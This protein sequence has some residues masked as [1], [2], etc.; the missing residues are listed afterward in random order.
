[1]TSRVSC[2]LLG[3][4]ASSVPGREGTGPGTSFL[5]GIPDGSGYISSMAKT[6]CHSILEKALRCYPA[7][8]RISAAIMHPGIYFLDWGGSDNEG[9]GN[10]SEL[11]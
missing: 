3:S 2:A 8:C 1:M 11:K 4:P 10:Y 7:S 9:D 5:D 6:I